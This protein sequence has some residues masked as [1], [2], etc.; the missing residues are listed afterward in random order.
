MCGH[1]HDGAG[2]VG[3]QYIVGNPYG[4]FLAVYRV[5]RSQT[6]QHNAGLVLCDFGSFKIGLLG[7]HFTVCHY[8]VPVFNGVFILID[9]RM[10]R[11]H[12]HVGNTE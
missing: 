10:L 4:N 7:C 5:Y 1:R 12:N 3:H 8:V 11:T 9:K 6:V 2:T